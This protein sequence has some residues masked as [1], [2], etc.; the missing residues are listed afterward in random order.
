[1]RP[2][3]SAEQSYRSVSDLNRR[4]E[5]YPAYNFTQLSTHFSPQSPAGFNQTFKQRYWI[6][7]SY[8]K[9]GGPVIVLDGGETDGSDRIVFLQSGI[10]KYLAEATGGVG[11]VLEHRY[12]GESY[13]SEVCI[14][15]SRYI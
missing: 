9:P 2:K 15:A 7:T 10:L 13:V 14:S 3:P 4:A 12:Y 11:I 6:D 8:Y 1:M 5:D